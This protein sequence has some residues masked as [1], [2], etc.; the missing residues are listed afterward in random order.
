MI[1]LNN[2]RKI[3]RRIGNIFNFREIRDFFQNKIG[4]LNDDK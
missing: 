4:K 2:Y 1:Q 3:G